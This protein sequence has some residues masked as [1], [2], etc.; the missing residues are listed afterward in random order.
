MD[1]GVICWLALPEGSNDAGWIRKSQ[2][3]MFAM[4]LLVLIRNSKIG[5]RIHIRLEKPHRNRDS[6]FWKTLVKAL[7]LDFE[8]NLT[9]SWPRILL[10]PVSDHSQEQRLDQIQGPT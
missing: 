8:T 1:I 3:L 9:D 7:K 6:L 5:K 10:L 2:R 4:L